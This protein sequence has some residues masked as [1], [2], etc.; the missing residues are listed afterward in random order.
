MALGLAAYVLATEILVYVII[1]RE[2]VQY[3]YVL[4]LAWGH[5]VYGRLLVRNRLT[6]I[7]VLWTVTCTVMSLFPFLPPVQQQDRK[8]QTYGFAL[9]LA[10]ML[11]GFF[12][13]NRRYYGLQHQI[14]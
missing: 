6:L 8:Q 5:V 11:A 7:L 14:K 3:L 13:F 4:L 12:L 1:D 10:L 2:F 9:C